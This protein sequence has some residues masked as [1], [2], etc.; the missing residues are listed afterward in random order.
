MSK[1][2]EQYDE[3]QEATAAHKVI[4][5]KVVAYT[6]HGVVADLG[7]KTEG[8]I[9]AA[10]FADTEIPRPEPNSTI[11]GQR[12]G[13]H[14]DGFTILS[15]LKVLRRR[16]SEKIQAAFKSKETI[17]GK[18]VDRIKGGLVVGL[19]VRA[20]LPGCQYGLRPA[21]NLDTWTGTAIQGGV[22]Q[23]NGG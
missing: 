20:F 4:E 22:T 18:G 21:Q 12:T 17:T 16:T 9:P 11:E 8:L 6:E 14:K 23:L 15:Y 19:G 7:G 3:K 5:V 13:E 10:E 2:P 1:L